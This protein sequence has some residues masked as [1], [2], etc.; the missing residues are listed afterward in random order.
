MSVKVFSCLDSNIFFYF[1][2]DTLNLEELSSRFHFKPGA[3]DA[4]LDPYE[5]VFGPFINPDE[6]GNF[7]G[8]VDGA[9]YCLFHPDPYDYRAEIVERAEKTLSPTEMELVT[10]VIDGY[11]EIAKYLLDKKL[12]ERLTGPENRDNRKNFKKKVSN[13]LCLFLLKVF[14]AKCHEH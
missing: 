4:A 11:K 7:P 14:H 9:T 5:G 12:P 10:K 13:L 3:N 1:D 8:L 6:R 2:T